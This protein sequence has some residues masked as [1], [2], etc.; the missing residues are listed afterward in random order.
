VE[1]GS[2]RVRENIQASGHLA[3]VN[4][5]PH[6]IQTQTASNILNEKLGTREDP[7]RQSLA[8]WRYAVASSRWKLE[9]S[10]CKLE[11]RSWKVELGNSTKGLLALEL[12]GIWRNPVEGDSQILTKSTKLEVSKCT[13][14]ARSWKLEGVAVGSWKL[15]VG[16]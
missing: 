1:V 7:R 14:E 5:V 10:H 9:G 4:A 3:N 11:V 15:K 2:L 13:L 6:G 12:P 16:S 8:S